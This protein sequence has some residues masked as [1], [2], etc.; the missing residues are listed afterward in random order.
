MRT[1]EA[2]INNPLSKDTAN[3]L[4]TKLQKN[5]AVS[6]DNI[7]LT[8]V[9][10]SEK[11]NEKS[12][13]FVSYLHPDMYSSRIVGKSITQKDIENQSPV[14][15]SGN[16][17]LEY[18]QDAK[19]YNT[20]DVVNLD[21]IKFTVV[22]SY[23]VCGNSGEIPY[24]VG[25]NHFALTKLQL[26]VPPDAT[27]N[28]KER[29]GNY[30]QKLIPGCKIT[31]PKPLVQ[32]VLGNMII[33]YA[34][35]LLIGISALINFL[36]I[37]KYMLESSR[38]DYLIFKICGCGN[39]KLFSVLFVEL[40]SLYTL[41][42]TIGTVLFAGIRQIYHTNS[43][44]ANSQ[45]NI[46]QVLLIYLVSILLIVMIMIPYLFKYRKQTVNSGGAI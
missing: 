33:S 19:H 9:L 35:G 12:R 17:D 22:G 6:L 23:H 20:G 11:T 8:F 24:T 2:D 29:L 38:E 30:V 16:E 26:L 1:I 4:M 32:K 46:S 7:Q 44:F 43:I 13:N 39:R 37:F 41:S 28:Q 36:F 21:G 45:F 25:L 14:F 42:F 27:D 31:L 15:V 5:P 10:N 18:R 34:A 40:V 3:S